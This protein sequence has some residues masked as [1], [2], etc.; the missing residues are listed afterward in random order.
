MMTPSAEDVID[1]SWPCSVSTSCAACRSLLYTAAPDTTWYF[2]MPAN[3]STFSGF[4][5]LPSS[6]LGILPNAALVGAKT[7]KGPSPRRAETRLAAVR[8]VTS[9][10]RSPV[11][12]AS[13]TMFFVGLI[14]GPVVVGGMST[15]SMM[16]TTPFVAAMSADITLELPLMVTPSAEDVIDTSWPCSVST[17]CE[18]CRSL[19]YTAAPDTTWY[20]RMSANSSTFSGSNNLPSSALG[21][22][23][24]AA[25]D[26]AKTVKGPAPSRAETRLAA[27]RAVTSVD[28]SLNL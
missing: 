17:S 28:R 2:R 19:L 9:V 10:D 12:C 7:V 8:A 27:A 24:N 6:A 15:V 13:S 20:F 4:N 3:S 23:P 26:G 1:T 14:D 5:N 18:A 22:L 21:I 16:C 11:L 25:L